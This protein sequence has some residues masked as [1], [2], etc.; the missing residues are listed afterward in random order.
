[1]TRRDSI[2]ITIRAG[3]VKCFMTHK[4]LPT[5]A[6]APQ[7]PKDFFFKKVFIYPSKICQQLQLQVLRFWSNFGYPLRERK[8]QYN[9]V[10]VLSAALQIL[11]VPDHAMA[12]WSTKQ[13]G[14]EATRSRRAIL[15]PISPEGCCPLQSLF[16]VWQSLQNLLTCGKG[17]NCQAQIYKTPYCPESFWSGSNSIWTAEAFLLPHVI[18]RTPIPKWRKR[19]DH[20]HCW[21]RW[22][23]FFSFLLIGKII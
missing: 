6:T 17:Q 15:Q 21:L 2:V 20:S 19:D 8:T 18:N 16:S 7:W 4:L 10:I 1:M 22:L 11:A 23:I 13:A 14:Q 3:K 12:W 9:N 5:T